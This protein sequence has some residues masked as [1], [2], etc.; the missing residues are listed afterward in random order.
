M[1]KRKNLEWLFVLPTDSLAGGAEQ[2][3]FNLVQNLSNN[4][5]KCKVVILT[6]RNSGQWDSLEDKC[7]IKYLYFNNVYLGFISSIP[8]LI[9]LSYKNTIQYLF[10]SQTLVNGLLGFLKKLGFFGNSKAIVRES[11][12]I[13][14]LL[15]GNKLKLYAFAY[16]LGYS[17]VDLIICQTDFMK[18][19]LLGAMPWMK[20]QM[21]MIVLNNPIS[22]ELIQQKSKEEIIELNS[23]DYI[24]AAGRLSPVKGFD[25]L[26]RSF[27]EIQNEFPNITLLILG[28]GQERD[29]LE[30]LINQLNL[31]DR[32][33]LVGFVKNV[34]PYFKKARLCVMSSRIEG[35]PN[36]LLQMMSMNTKVVCTLSAGGIDQID[37]IFTCEIENATELANSI[38]SCLQ[39]DTSSNRRLFDSDLSTRTIESFV[40]EIIEH[41]S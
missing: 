19:Q 36:V 21:K 35:F 33:K 24:V 29:Y 4:S 37:G 14:H 2:L 12:S 8:Y 30:K 25:V 40:N 34:Y 16:K 32:I 41:S 7:D 9:K 26:I 15:K 20:T 28:E 18:E 38:R 31:A 17:G 11:N 27:N 1:A 22:H 13:F 5:K 10:S 6:K 39:S 3:I 23:L